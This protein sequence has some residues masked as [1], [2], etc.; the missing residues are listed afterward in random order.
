M[1]IKHLLRLAGVVGLVAMAACSTGPLGVCVPDAENPNQE[2]CPA[3][4]DVTVGEVGNPPV[5]MDQ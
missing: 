5:T 2:N 3:P 4:G 1:V